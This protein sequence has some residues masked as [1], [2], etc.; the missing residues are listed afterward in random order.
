[1]DR[2]TVPFVSLA[3]LISLTL[4]ALA[5]CGWHAITANDVI[6]L[7]GQQ[8][9]LTAYVRRA[10][11]PSLHLDIPGARVQFRVDGKV[12]ATAVTD[13]DGRAVAHAP[14]SPDSQTVE[15]YTRLKKDHLRASAPIYRWSL[16]KTVIAVDL[17]ETISATRYSDLFIAPLDGSP[18]IQ[19]AREAL[20]ALSKDYQ[21]LYFSARPEFLQ[22]KTRQWLRDNGFPPA[23]YL[24]ADRFAACLDQTGHK[25][26][27]LVD[28][29]QRWPNLLIGIGD[30]RVD[31]KAY[32]AA[33]ML[34]F[35]VNP[36]PIGS[37]S[38][39]CV[40]VKDWPSLQA[41]F[42]AHRERLTRPAE[43]AGIIRQNGDQ[44]RPFF[45]AAPT[46]RAEEL[47]TTP[48]PVP[49]PTHTATMVQRTGDSD[50]QF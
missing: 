20:W 31:D 12:V 17:D 1:M 21:I 42:K 8:A 24:G 33:D 28:M 26:R 14:I 48:Q 49:M 16:D 4:S 44:L 18:P 6:T 47:P 50:S 38:Q 19:G 2:Y 29:K 3:A 39:R 22:D 7:D 45:A 5:G 41:F 23:P 46:Q 34:T 43:L 9:T 15:A 35:I 10:Y 25:R 36:R 27:M 13:K 30:K 37:Y 11:G 32:G 40:M